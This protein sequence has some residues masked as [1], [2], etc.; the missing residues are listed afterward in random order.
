MDKRKVTRTTVRY[1][2]REPISTCVQ[3]APDESPRVVVMS[4]R[5]ENGLKIKADINDVHE[6]VVHQRHIAGD[7]TRR[8][9]EHEFGAHPVHQTIA[10]PAERERRSHHAHQS[11][12]ENF[13]KIRFG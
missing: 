8:Q 11:I 3:R 13:R 9:R 1:V 5:T 10:T 2:E 6:Q 7:E 4:V 12:W